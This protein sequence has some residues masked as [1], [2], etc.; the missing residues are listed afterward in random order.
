MPSFAETE[1]ETLQTTL[2]QVRAAILAITAG[3][4]SYTLTTG[5]TTIQANRGNLATLKAYERELRTDIAALE[6]RMCGTGPTV[7]RPNY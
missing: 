1:L 4:Q 5:Q 7:V 3:A 6:H 2:T